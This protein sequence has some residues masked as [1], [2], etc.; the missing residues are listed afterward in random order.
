MRGNAT[1]N[2]PVTGQRPSHKMDFMT[3]IDTTRSLSPSL[4]RHCPISVA[5]SLSM[6]NRRRLCLPIPL[7]RPLLE[8]TSFPQNSRVN[9]GRNIIRPRVFVEEKVLHSRRRISFV[10]F[11]IP[12][13]IFRL[14]QV[15]NISVQ[16]DERNRRRK[17][18]DIERHSSNYLNK[19]PRDWGGKF[20]GRRLEEG[21]W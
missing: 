11:H 12:S 7:E 13:S 19:I 4:P 15:S 14:T 8:S 5:L 17:S 20:A 18:D 3:P 21:W 1:A 2:T 6:D 16:L 9:R 10:L